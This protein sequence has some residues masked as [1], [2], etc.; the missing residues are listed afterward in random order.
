LLALTSRRGLKAAILDLTT[1]DLGTRGTPET[2]RLEATES[3]RIL[4]VDRYILDLP[5]ARFGEGTRERDRIITALRELLRA[6]AQAPSADVLRFGCPLNNLAQEVSSQDDELR[7]RLETVMV[8]WVAALRDALARG[9]GAGTVRA[10][11]DPERVARFVVA[12]IEGAMSLA[13]TARDASVLRGSYEE[14]GS[15]LEAL[16]P[17]RKSRARRGA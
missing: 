4:G 11:A 16:R 9:Q 8:R 3:A 15:Y 14:L 5:D 17:A 10:D 6:Q 12:A 13:K 7:R 2:R 1:G